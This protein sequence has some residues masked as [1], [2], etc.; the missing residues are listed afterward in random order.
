MEATGDSWWLWA[1]GVMSGFSLFAAWIYPTLLAPLFNKFSPVEDGELKDGIFNFSKKIGFKT[2]GIYIM[3]ASTRSTHGNAYFTGL[4]GAKRIVLF[5]TL[6][7]SLS[8]QEIIAVLAHELGHFKLNHVRWGLIRGILMTGIMFYLMSLCLPL[9][10]FYK[11]FHLEGVSFY[12]ALLVFTMWFGL[13]DFIIQPIGSY[14]SRKNEF[15]ADAFA[16]K[17]LGKEDS[18]IG[19]LVKLR[20]SNHSMPISHPL[21]SAFYHSHP[22]LME[23]FAA[24]RK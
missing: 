6:I 3:D 14:L 10:E 19:A 15:A 1:W 23:R 8:S 24:L 9:E 5:D 4:F 11:A 22:P 21:Y 17:N 7:K 18:L 16:K 2:A 20:Q 13:L 12:G